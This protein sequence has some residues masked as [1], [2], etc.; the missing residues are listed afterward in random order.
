MRAATEN[1][2]ENGL[3]ETSGAGRS[4]YQLPKA[5]GVHLPAA[6]DRG[7]QG[8]ISGLTVR[9]SLTFSITRAF[10]TEDRISGAG[11]VGY[12]LA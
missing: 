6:D 11:W 10:R 9:E 8:S 7:Q 4:L 1:G 12:A 3:A 5:H 2:R